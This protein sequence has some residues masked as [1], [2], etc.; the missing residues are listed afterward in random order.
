[1]YDGSQ[2]WSQGV[3]SIKV[4]TIQSTD[5]PN[6]LTR[7]QLAWLCNG[8]VRDGGIT[9]RATWQPIGLKGTRLGGNTRLWQGGYLYQPDNG[10]PYLVYQVSGLVQ[11]INLDGSQRVLLSTT[12]GLTNPPDIPI[13]FF[14]QGEQFLVI[15]AGDFSTLP[16]FWDGTTLRRST[17]QSVSLGVTAA[18]FNAP[19]INDYVDINVPTWSGANNQIFE[20]NGDTGAKYMQVRPAQF[21]GLTNTGASATPGTIIPANTGVVN[22]AGATVCKLLV[23]FTIPALT[24]TANAFTTIQYTGVVGDQVTIA[25]QRFQ[26]ASIGIAPPAAGHI[27]AVNLNQP[28]ATPNLFPVSLVSIQEIGAA[29]PMDYYQGRLWYGIGRQLLAGDIVRG[30]SGTAFYD[31][32]DSILKVTENPLCLAG[33]GFTVPDNAGNIRSIFHNANINATLGQGNLY[34]GTKKA[35]YSLQV[36]VTRTDWIAANNNN[37]P[38]MTVVQINNGTAND[39]SCTLVNGDVWYQTLEPSIASLFTQVRNF[40]QWGNISLSANENRILQFNDRSLV[41][42]SSGIYFDNRM[43]QTALP[44]Q[45]PQGVVHDAIVPLDFVPI[46]SF[47]AALVPNWEG[48]YEGLPVLQ[49]FV[50]EFGGR[51]RGFAAIVSV[52]PDTE[53]EIQLWEF[54]TAGRFEGASPAEEIAGKLTG[55]VPGN[56]VSWYAEFPAFTAGDLFQLKNLVCAELGI[57]KLYGTVDFSMDYRADFESCWHLWWEWQLCSA[58]NSAETVD[59]PVSYPL[60]QFCDGYRQSITLPK[61]QLKCQPQTKR[62]TSQGYMFQVRLRVKGF[63]RIRALRLYMTEVEKALYD[64][65]VQPPLKTTI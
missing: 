25:G 65:M 54:T 18:N 61:P 34:I 6:G 38:T 4:P 21:L 13:A 24:V 30:P 59:E 44:R 55:V 17:G 53:G 58:R 5:N 22:P 28:A 56:R 43:L 41:R 7:S 39:R 46:S 51:E 8:T 9:Q 16:L 40:S 10:D 48:H 2:D 37:Q 15:Q 47:G 49:M 11:K 36:P 60:T 20:I 35:I 12:L 50:G 23:P 63:C 33:D 52:A 31:F 19:A 45:L 3:D 42:F 29:G 32:R 26:V 27:F 62:P 14:C 1:M 57:D 64:N